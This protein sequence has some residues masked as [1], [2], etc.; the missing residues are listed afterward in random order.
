MRLRREINATVAV[1]ALLVAGCAIVAI[2]FGFGRSLAVARLARQSSIV[3][4]LQRNLRAEHAELSGTRIGTSYVS[5]TLDAQVGGDLFDVW[6]LPGDR[7]FLLSADFSGKGVGAAVNV[8]FVQF[9]IRT[10]SLELD[11]PAEILAR[12]NRLF[13]ATIPDP[14]LFVV[15][16]LGR[17]HAATRTLTFASAGH[18]SAYVRRGRKVEVLPVT[19]PIIGLGDG[20]G[21]ACRTLELAEGDT[22]VLATDGLTES[23]DRNGEIL[24]DDEAMRLIADGPLH[25]QELCDRLVEE[26]STRAQG[27]IKDDLALLAIEV[28]AGRPAGV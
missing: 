7:D 19:G 1:S 16:F 27:D 6:N 5:A 21:F 17:Y 28:T 14:T 24:G 8:A 25:P 23:R 20:D 10:L 12:F 11:D 18:G 22:V 13:A 3:A 2:V 15:V 26:V 9:A 4:A